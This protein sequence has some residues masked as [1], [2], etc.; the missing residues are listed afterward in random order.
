MFDELLQKPQPQDPA[1]T[2]IYHELPDDSIVCV[3][4]SF[5]RAW[6]AIWQNGAH[7]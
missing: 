2:Q 4:G 7:S 1:E 3:L 6:K 5:P